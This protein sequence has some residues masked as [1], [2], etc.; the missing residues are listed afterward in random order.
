MHACTTGRPSLKDL[1][2]EDKRR[3]KQLIEQLARTSTE[4]EA[5]ENR[6]EEERKQFTLLLEKLK[7][8]H[9][10]V[11]SEKKH[12]LII[13]LLGLLSVHKLALA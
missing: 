11:V 6:V 10:K 12:I 3:L 8:Q 1:C 5:M 4:K 7:K 2:P 9:H 13:F